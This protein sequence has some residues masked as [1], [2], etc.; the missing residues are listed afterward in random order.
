MATKLL[1]FYLYALAKLILWRHQPI[2]IAI[3]GNVGKTSAKEAIFTVLSRKFNV[4]RGEKNYN[5]EIGVPLTIIGEEHHGKNVI[6]WLFAAVR[7]LIRVT[8]GSQYPRVLIL[9]MGAD[10][11]GDIKYLAR[12]AKPHIAVV[13]GIGETPVHI[14]F[15]DTA[16]KIAEEKA[17]L[18]KALPFSGHAVLNTDDNRVV[19][20]AKL[21]N[22]AVLT[23][24][25]S[26]GANVRVEHWETRFSGGIPEGISFKI[27][28]KGSVIPIRLLGSLSLPQALAAASAF[29]VGVI[30]GMNAVEIS[31]ALRTYTPPLGR[32]RLLRG[33]KQSLILDDTYN[34]APAAMEAALL[35]LK[36]LP[37]KRKIAVIGDMLELGEHT[38]AAH[39]KIG[40]LAAAAA[41]LIFTVGSRMLF[42]DEEIRGAGFDQNA[43]Y[44]CADSREVS[45]ILEP[46]IR[47]GDLIL[48][49]GSQGI[50]MERV[51]E[52]IMAEPEKAKDLLVRQTA[53]WKAKL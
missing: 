6:L 33:S 51:V 42:A 10:H 31:E 38:E 39:R 25:T 47:P 13:T 49:K 48:V 40:S 35:T 17:E 19:A 8:M 26:E 7:V 1:Q 22:A 2:I 21:T 14:E 46:M 5:N 3:T 9:E 20:M 45:N 30:M 32:L 52:D 34:A 23:Y 36:N 24:G 43:H 16:E 15:F 11:P 28:H 37:A 44:H 41:D 12:L 4:R 27:T 18:L 50:R 29:A 53:E